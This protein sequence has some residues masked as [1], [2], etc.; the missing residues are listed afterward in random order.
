MAESDENILVTALSVTVKYTLM[1]I[2]CLFQTY[3]TRQI[4]VTVMVCVWG[5]RLSGYLLYRIIQI[6]SDDR[7]ED[8]RNSCA[9]FAVFWSFQV[10][11]L[12]YFYL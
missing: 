6:G 3:L 9:R 12:M 11:F 5:I 10:R 7:F 8:K 4:V 1:F 2:I